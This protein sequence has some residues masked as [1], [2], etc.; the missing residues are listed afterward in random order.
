[1]ATLHVRPPTTITR[2]TEYIPQVIEFV[3]R[4]HDDRQIAYERNGS[5]YFSVARFTKRLDLTPTS[6]LPPSSPSPSSSAA[7]LSPPT[8]APH[9]YGKL[10]PA[11]GR[12]L[13]ADRRGR[14]VSCP[15]RRRVR[16]CTRPTSP[17][18]RR[19]SRANHP[20]PHPGALA[21]PAGTSVHRTPH[22]T[23]SLPAPV[24]MRWFSACALT[25]PL[26]LSSL[27]S[28]CV[29]VCA[30]CSAMATEVIGERMDIHSGGMDLKFPH[31]DN[32]LAQSE[33]ALGTH[34]W[35]NH[36]WHAGHLSIKG[37]KMS[38]SLKNFITIRQLL[39]SYTPRQ[40]RL[41]FLLSP[42][43]SGINFSEDGLAAAKAKE[44]ELNEFFLN[45]QVALRSL[46]DTTLTPQL[47]TADDH[48]LHDALKAAQTA[49]HAALCDSFDY[50]TAMSLLSS[51]VQDANRYRGRAD[52]K[53]VVLLA[54]ARYVDSMVGVFGLKGEREEY[55]FA[56]GGGAAPRTSPPP[57]ST[58][59]AR[60]AT[61]SARR[62][63]SGRGG[64][65]R[66][67]R[68]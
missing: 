51:I 52:A 36:F 13:V 27:S 4:I 19:L 31:H 25:S 23:H 6:P 60:S 49:V 46:P 9:H 43:D 55:G 18:G 24:T 32:E 41:L 39:S 1:M 26:C 62:R 14:R 61:R 38:K 64:K 28:M 20:G 50:P 30:E 3:R 66:R 16:S 42:W 33:A 11:S 57:C 29:R 68:G 8:P 45:T 34:Q 54:V 63:G 65:G 48:R 35:V 22:T 17:C 67:R 58:C 15:R 56:A 2:V 7:S 37:L 21:V 5:V 44:A 53:R 10:S 12:S 59:S 47:W 40:L